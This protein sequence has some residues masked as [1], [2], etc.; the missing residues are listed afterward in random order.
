MK[1]AIAVAVLPLLAS[2]VSHGPQ[3][4][5]G[6]QATAQRHVKMSRTGD[7]MMES[8]IDGF[9]SLYDRYLV[10]YSMGRRNAYLAEL[11]G[12][13]YDV[14]REVSLATIDGDG[15]G[16][17]C[18]FG[19]D[20]VGYRRTGMDQQCRIIGLEELTD[21][22]REELGVPKP[23]PKKKEKAPMEENKSGETK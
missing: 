22:R 5:L 20:A 3:S 13:C 7:C 19:R 14:G 2:C 10:L 12:E 1:R 11:S 21:E 16:Q 8:S 18:G 9:E 6:T 23:V 17:I 4:Q 15:N